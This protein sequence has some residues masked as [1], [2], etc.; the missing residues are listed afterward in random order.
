MLH[1]KDE[2]VSA[3]PVDYVVPD[4]GVDNEISASEQSLA[5]AESTLHH[6]TWAPTFKHPDGFNKDYPVAN[7]GVDGDI[8]NT[9]T[10]LKV[11]E[12]ITKHQWNWK[13]RPAKD[14]VLNK[15]VPAW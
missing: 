2:G 14:F 1:F 10:S 6:G 15:G 5:A 7:F 11:A 4:F 12:A 8:L 9:A 13:L 3:H